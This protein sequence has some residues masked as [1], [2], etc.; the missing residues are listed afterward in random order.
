MHM[1]SVNLDQGVADAR[2]VFAR[3]GTVA[4]TAFHAEP[5]SNQSFEQAC[6]Q[7]APSAAPTNRGDQGTPVLVSIR[8]AVDP[9]E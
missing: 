3:K 8:V 7:R 4:P 6:Q 5:Y 1:A 2:Y 9:P